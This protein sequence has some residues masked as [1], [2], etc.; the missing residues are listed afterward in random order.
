M[1]EL[2]F[3]K[4]WAAHNPGTLEE[5]RRYWDL[6]A[7]EFNEM[8]RDPDREERLE[9]VAYLSGKGALPPEGVVL[10]LG[11]GAGSYTLEFA[12]RVRHVT[13]VDIS[14]GMI[15]FARANVGEAGLNNSTFLTL[16]WQEL[17][18][19]AYGFRGAFDLVFASMSG[20]VDS[21]ESLLKLHAASRKYCFLSAFVYRKDM[22]QQSLADRIF[23]DLALAPL[24]GSAYYAFNILWQHGL[25][26][27]LICKDRTWITEWDTQAALATYEEHLLA[28]AQPGMDLR[29]ELLRAL[30][31]LSVH[32]RVRRKM[33]A[34]TAWLFWRAG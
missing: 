12:R 24:A 8:V 27:D 9:L 5:T 18:L 32:G 23:P 16:P 28:H 33:E 2:P 25:Y 10:D 3:A 4:L 6:R 20:A 26:A 34:K 1:D 29:K 19:D 14:P 21:E 31:A 22:L 11:C 7:G 17:D 13:G 15:E 30:D